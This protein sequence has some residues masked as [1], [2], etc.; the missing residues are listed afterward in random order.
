MAL[1][2]PTTNLDHENVE[3]LAQAL[4][5]IVR[6]GHGL[7]WEW[8][9]GRHGWHGNGV[10]GAWEWD[11]GEHGWHGNEVLGAWEWDTGG[12]GWHGNGV[13]GTWMAWGWGGVKVKQ[14]TCGES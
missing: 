7:A 8:D 3:G 10:L 11:T 4:A 12:H 2:E 14:V 5:D 13:L 6:W 9:T 1:D